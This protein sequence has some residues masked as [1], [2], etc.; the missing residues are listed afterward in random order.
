MIGIHYS[1]FLDRHA[2]AIQKLRGLSNT[3]HQS[4]HTPR[5]T[6][7]K[8]LFGNCDN[9][10]HFASQSRAVYKH[11]TN[12][13]LN[14]AGFLT[15]GSPL[16]KHLSDPKH[17]LHNF[18]DCKVAVKMSKA[19]ISTEIKSLI[20]EAEIFK[21]VCFLFAPI[22]SLALNTAISANVTNA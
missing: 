10:L 18:K 2:V 8:W 13:C 3:L 9:R 17:A 7:G 1:L 21:K 5:S 4:K 14:V 16:A 22:S 12:K 6:T 11:I 20:R 15:D 19:H